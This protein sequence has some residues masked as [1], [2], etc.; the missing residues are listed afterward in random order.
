MKKLLAIAWLVTIGLSTMS[1]A[2]AATSNEL[3]TRG[4]N[5]GLTK[6]ESRTSFNATAPVTREQA[7]KMITAWIQTHHELNRTAADIACTFNDASTIDET[8]S[9]NVELACQYGLFKGYKGAFM[10]KLYLTRSD[11]NTLIERTLDKLPAYKSLAPTLPSLSSSF[12][13]RGEL[14]TALY[15]IN[16]IVEGQIAIEKNEMLAVQQSRLNAAKQL[17]ASKNVKHYTV[18]QQHSCFCAPNSTHPVQFDVLSG[19]VVTGTLQ[20]M[21]ETDKIAPSQLMVTPMTVE[22]AFAFI[23]EAIDRKADSMTIKYDATLGNPTEV[24]IDYS[25]MM[26]DE[27]SYYTYSVK[28]IN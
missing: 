23:Q 18:T 7:A 13:T 20:D 28:V 24:S 25:T 17:W 6:Y 16:A 15:R 10:P 21:S 3:I 27:E 1:S 4:H 19:S 12:L 5:N 9:Y 14:L 8:L 2:L 22:D 11:V 26:A